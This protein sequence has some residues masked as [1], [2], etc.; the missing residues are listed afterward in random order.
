M[1]GKGEEG[2]RGSFLAIFGMVTPP[3][4]IGRFTWNLVCKYIIMSGKCS[5]TF[6]SLLTIFLALW[7]KVHFSLKDYQ[8]EIALSPLPLGLLTWNLVCMYIGVVWMFIYIFKSLPCQI[9]GHMAK[10]KFL[11]IFYN[12]PQTNWPISI[13]FGR[14]IYIIHLYIFM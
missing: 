2:E 4:L 3:R 8:Q 14:N 1:C 10:N 6:K 7:P 13:T 5:F 11:H 9:F 12:I